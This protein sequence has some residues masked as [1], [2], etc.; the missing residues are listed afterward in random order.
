MGAIP[1]VKTKQEQL[2]RAILRKIIE[3]IM[4]V[5]LKKSTSSLAKFILTG[6]PGTIVLA[7]GITLFERL[8]TIGV[9]LSL[10]K[11]F[12]NE[13]DKKTKADLEFYNTVITGAYQVVFSP[14]PVDEATK[15][16]VIEDIKRATDRLAD[17]RSYIKK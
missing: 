7:L 12:F 2:A 10:N 17:M 3:S 16:K 11:T 9:Q 1:F 14:D 15:D 4:A 13:V 5:T 6:V 8:G